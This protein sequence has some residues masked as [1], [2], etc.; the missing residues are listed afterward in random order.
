M[1]EMKFANH[2]LNEFYKNSFKIISSNTYELI[3]DSLKPMDTDKIHKIINE[4]N[5]IMHEIDKIESIIIPL[6]K[7]NSLSEEILNILYDENCDFIMV[8]SLCNYIDELYK[9]FKLSITEIIEYV[10]TFSIIPELTDITNELNKKLYDLRLA[11]VTELLN[12]NNKLYKF[13]N[14]DK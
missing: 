3:R 6:F 8:I 7:L 10:L 9:N 4:H 14:Y 5:K 11:T 2:Y 1:I 12:D 13:N